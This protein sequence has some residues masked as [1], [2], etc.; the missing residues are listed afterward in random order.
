[1]SP[2]VSCVA[3]SSRTHS[4]H[5]EQS[6]CG[7]MPLLMLKYLLRFNLSFYIQHRP[8]LTMVKCTNPD[9]ALC[10]WALRD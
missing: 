3:I 1:M 9:A 5:W 6:D 10:Y 8:L 7:N 2:Q 4:G